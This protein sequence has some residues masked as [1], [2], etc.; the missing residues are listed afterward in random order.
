MIT[1]NQLESDRC[2]PVRLAAAYLAVRTTLEGYLLIHEDGTSLT[3]YQVQ[4]IMHS[5]L[6][7]SGM[8]GQGE[9]FSSHSFRIGAA[10]TAFRAGLSEE[11]IMQV[12]HWESR[13]YKRYVRS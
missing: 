12:G 7:K 3:K 13:C 8:K 9:K 4:C 1:L 2:C 6:E 5:C 11:C 10:T